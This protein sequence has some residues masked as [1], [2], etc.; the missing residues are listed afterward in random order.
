MTMDRNG[1]FVI[2]RNRE[3]ASSKV[4]SEIEL[5]FL[6]IFYEKWSVWVIL[7]SFLSEIKS[8]KGQF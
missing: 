5:L 1:L 4:R 7:R 8:K 3:T 2:R 6:V